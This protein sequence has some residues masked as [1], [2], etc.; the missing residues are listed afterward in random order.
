VEL[1]LWRKGAVNVI[2]RQPARTNYRHWRYEGWVMA[3]G[4]RQLLQF[5]PAG[6]SNLKRAE[7]SIRSARHRAQFYSHSSTRQAN[8]E[9]LSGD[10]KYLR[11]RLKK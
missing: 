1:M 3:L 5:S 7:L 8:S 4:I 10:F 6:F 2:T 9:S 11:R